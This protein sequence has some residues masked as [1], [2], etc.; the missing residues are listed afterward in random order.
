MGVTLYAVMHAILVHGWKGTPDYGWFPWLRRELEAVGYTTESLTLPNPLL[1]DRTEWVEVIKKAV[2]DP[3][4]VLIGHSLG[5]PC[6]LFAL[7]EYAGDPIARVVLVSGFGR[8][9]LF[10]HAAEWFGDAKIDFDLVRQR[11]KSWAVLHTRLDPIVPF[12]EGEWL[13]KQLHVPMVEVE[14]H[15]VGH[16]AP[17]DFAFEIPEIFQAVVSQV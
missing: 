10:P 15:P 4:V 3:E 8:P 6:I 14:S 13:A 17:E 16:L 5:C 7:Q 1:P 11:A 9:F 12:R 2:H